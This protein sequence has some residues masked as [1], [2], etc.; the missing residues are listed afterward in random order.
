[1]LPHVPLT[2]QNKHTVQRSS[3]RCNPQVWN[4]ILNIKPCIGKM[5]GAWEPCSLYVNIEKVWLLIKNTCFQKMTGQLKLRP[6]AGIEWNNWKQGNKIT[7][8]WMIDFGHY[9]QVQTRQYINDRTTK[10]SSYGGN[11]VISLQPGWKSHKIMDYF[12]HYVRVQTHQ[13]VDLF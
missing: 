8:E 1:M 4:I 6:I 11:G 12:G 2:S 10:T 9:V 7:K 3:K 5:L 13:Y